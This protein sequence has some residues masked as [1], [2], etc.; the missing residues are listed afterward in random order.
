[1]IGRRLAVPC[2]LLVLAI[3]SAAHAQAEGAGA[4]APAKPP[5]AKAGAPPKA[6][7]GKADAKADASPPDPDKVTWYAQ[8][9]AQGPGGLNVT[10]FWSKG[11]KFR[12]ETV[13]AGH[14]IVSLVNGDWYFAYDVT[15]GLGIK[16]RRTPAAIANDAPYL[17]PF[18]NEALKLIKQGAEKVREETFAGRETEIYQLTDRLGKRVVWVSKDQL[19]IP[20]RV[21]FF[22]RAMGTRQATDYVDWLTGLTLPDEFFTPDPN[23]EITEYEFEE[24]LS[25]TGK[26]GSVGPVPVLYADLL[27]GW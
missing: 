24:W 15:K 10:H 7:D 25:F 6:P 27:R 2:L 14:K 9:L 11:S 13:I 16:V 5:D 19:N 26:I 4:G 20:L 1:M 17:R 12:A 3:A 21:E 18:G 8:A 22:N 23:V